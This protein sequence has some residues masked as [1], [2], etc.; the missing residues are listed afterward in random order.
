MPCRPAS[1]PQVPPSSPSL[2]P[3]PF[4][5]PSLFLGFLRD[6]ILS[7]GVCLNYSECSI[8][9]IRNR[10][11]WGREATQRPVCP[12]SPVTVT[13]VLLGSEMQ[14]QPREHSKHRTNPPVRRPFLTPGLRG[15]KGSIAPG[16]SSLPARALSQLPGGC[17]LGLSLRTTAAHPGPPDFTRKDSPAESLL[18]NLQ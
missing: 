4:P 6:N 5:A 12:Q 8:Q 16:V 3:S 18:P 14:S 2:L 1:P 13:S 17:G 11:R 15:R 7:T 9:L 10:G